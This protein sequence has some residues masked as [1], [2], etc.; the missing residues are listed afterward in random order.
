MTKALMTA[1]DIRS[2]RCHLAPECGAPGGKK[3]EQIS[4]HGAF[5]LSARFFVV[6]SPVP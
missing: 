4:P 6:H 3:P 1:R 2:F 5:T